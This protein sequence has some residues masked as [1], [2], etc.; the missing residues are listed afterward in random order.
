[1]LEKPLTSRPVLS[2]RLARVP[3][4][5]GAFAIA[6]G[7]AVG[8]ASCGATA[9]TQS[10]SSELIAGIAA[11]DTGRYSAAAL[12]Y[13]KVLAKQ[14]NNVYALFDLGD[15]QQFQNQDASAAMHYREALA[16][17]PNFESAMYNLATLDA[18]TNPNEAKALYDQVLSISPNDADA[19]FNLGYV[20]IS[21]HQKAAGEGQ[22]KIAVKLDPSL[23][24]RETKS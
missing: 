17:D 18:S 13:Q 21:L 9:A 19:H 3:R 11:Q 23:K 16:L 6:G 8:L 20:L 14:P 15:A 22:I 12:D 10:V 2:G 7:M 5:L 1:M 4:R 24:S